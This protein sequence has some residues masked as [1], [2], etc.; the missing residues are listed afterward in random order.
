MPTIDSVRLAKSPNDR[1]IQS[2]VEESTSAPS[3][4][5]RST[6][7]DHAQVLVHPRGDPQP[8]IGAKFQIGSRLLERPLNPVERRPV[9]AAIGVGVLHLV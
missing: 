8:A 7:D 6:S 4:V 1:L 3:A 2:S 9:A 5:S